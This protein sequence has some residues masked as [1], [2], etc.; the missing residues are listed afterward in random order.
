[1]QG[2]D[3]GALVHSIRHIHTWYSVGSSKLRIGIS[4]PHMDMAELDCDA[5]AIRASKEEKGLNRDHA[6][7]ITLQN[8]IV[9]AAKQ[10]LGRPRKQ[11]ADNKRGMVAAPPAGRLIK[12]SLR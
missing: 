11:S 6:N 2:T 10:N 12:W 7:R 9:Q 5:A 1:M 3:T 8:R 4:E